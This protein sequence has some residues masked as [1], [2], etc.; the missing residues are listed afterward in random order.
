MSRNARFLAAGLLVALLLAAVV[1][2]WASGSPD[3]LNKV[4]IDKGFADSESDHRMADGP[5]EGYG[6]RGVD[7]KWLSNAIAGTSGVGITLVIGAGLFLLLCRSS[8]AAGRATR[9]DAKR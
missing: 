5:L 2:F 3:G 9:D 7:N 6:T 8:A 1:S 4:A